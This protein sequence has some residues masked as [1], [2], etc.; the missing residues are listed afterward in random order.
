[1]NMRLRNGCTESVKK[2]STEQPNLDPV[3]Y[4]LCWRHRTP[5][6]KLD[7]RLN[8]FETRFPLEVFLTRLSAP[9][10][11]RFGAKIEVVR[12][13]H[14]QPDEIGFGTVLPQESDLELGERRELVPAA[15][16]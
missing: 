6:R 4:F 3:Y 16:P 13:P 14:D 10:L 12:V 11:V 7:R 2:R 5:M 9:R 15:D 1:M 8:K